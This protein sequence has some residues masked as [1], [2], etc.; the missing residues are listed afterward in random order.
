MTANLAPITNDYIVGCVAE[1][2]DRH[3]VADLDIRGYRDKRSEHNADSEFDVFSDVRQRVNQIDKITT[4]VDDG[5]VAA[6]FGSWIADT[7]DEHI[8]CFDL[9]IVN[10]TEYPSLIFVPVERIGPAVEKSL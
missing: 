10:G 3:M 5:R 6:Q 4:P 8:V 1:C 9:V 2:S 7:P